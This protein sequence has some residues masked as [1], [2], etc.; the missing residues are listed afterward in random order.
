MVIERKIV[1]CREKLVLRKSGGGEEQREEKKK[2]NILSEFF[3]KC[4]LAERYR[5]NSGIDKTL[6]M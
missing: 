5:W 1:R 2:K 3:F 6:Y 4:Y